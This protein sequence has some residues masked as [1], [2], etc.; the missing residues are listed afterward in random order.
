[1]TR[2]LAFAILIET[3]GDHMLVNRG[4]I[5]GPTDLSMVKQLTVK[6]WISPQI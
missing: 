4:K 2:R 1:M 6:Q 5:R 3:I